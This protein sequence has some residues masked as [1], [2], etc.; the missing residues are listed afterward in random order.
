MTAARATWHVSRFSSATLY[1]PVLAH[2]KPVVRELEEDST[3]G[4][5]EESRCS[6]SE[7]TAVHTGREEGVTL[8]GPHLGSRESQQRRVSASLLLSRRAAAMH[9]PRALIPSAC[10]PAQLRGNFEIPPSIAS[11]RTK[12]V[13]STARLCSSRGWAVLS[14]VESSN[15]DTADAALSPVCGVA[16][17]LRKTSAGHHPSDGVD[18]CVCCCSSSHQRDRFPG[19]FSTN[20]GS[21]RV[22]PL[23]C[24]PFT[25]LASI[26]SAFSA[27]FFRH[28]SPVAQLRGDRLLPRLPH[29]R[30]D[31]GRRRR[32]PS[33]HTHCKHHQTS[34]IAI[35]DLFTRAHSTSQPSI[36]TLPPSSP[37]GVLFSCCQS[38][39]SRTP[40]F[41][42]P[43]PFLLDSNVFLFLLR[44]CLLLRL[45]V[46]LVVRPREVG[47]VR[48]GRGDEEGGRLRR[49]PVEGHL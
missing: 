20:L 1:R 16:L 14:T 39:V 25:V 6:H 29:P 12:S 48:C 30:L 17:L 46:R 15:D 13:L 9:R 32:R 26:R 35:A 7:V 27:P 11:H 42:L 45:L 18:R 34:T 43:L 22:L 5:A 49:R 3:A 41:G 47:C 31:A 19:Q 10:R 44:L 2:G 24:C 38:P 4:G 40:L 36:A 8:S 21:L 23:P 28:L 33:S 37:L